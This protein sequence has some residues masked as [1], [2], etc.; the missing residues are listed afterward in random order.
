MI[1]CYKIV[2]GLVDLDFDNFLNG[3][4]ALVLEDMDTSCTK[5]Q[6]ARVSDKTF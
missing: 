4:D 6:H 5:N 3:I 1:R 2:F